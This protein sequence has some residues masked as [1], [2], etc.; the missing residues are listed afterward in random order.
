VSDAEQS[1][2][3]H[4]EAPTAGFATPQYV[5]AAEVESKELEAAAERFTGHGEVRRTTCWP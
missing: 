5:L 3:G 2:A 1:D 4:D